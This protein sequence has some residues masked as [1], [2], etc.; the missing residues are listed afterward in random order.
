MPKAAFTQ[1]QL[2]P[3][4]RAIERRE[5]KLRREIAEERERAYSE[6][7][8]EMREPSGD[9][10]DHAFARI[11]AEIEHQRI[12]GHLA[13]IRDL[14]AARERLESGVFGACVDCG[15]PI[16]RARLTAFPAAAR[17]AICQDRFERNP[18][19]RH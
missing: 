4:A 15:E 5:E 10:A 13:E 1:R 14:A 9:V 11:S 8:S 7:F 6:G 12:Q 18:A 16:E 19:I 17:C 2:R 3:L